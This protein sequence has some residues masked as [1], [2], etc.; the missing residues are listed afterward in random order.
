M[1]RVEPEPSWPSTWQYSYKYDLLELYGDDAS[2]GYTYAYRNRLGIASELIASVAAPPASV[3]DV[4]GGQGN[5]SLRL[6]E[7][8][9][10]VT[11]NDL[12]GDLAGYVALKHEHGQIDYRP[13]NL[14]DLDP[15]QPF[16]IVLLSEV[17][18]HVAH[19]D[20]L[21]AKAARLVAPGGSVVLTTPNGEY[22][23]NPLPKFSDC[24]DPSM[25]ESAQFKPDADGHIFLLYAGEVRSLAA[26][27]GLRVQTLQLFTNPVTTGH[28]RTA[29]LL[30]RLP[31]KAVWA[32]ERATRRLPNPISRKV[33]VQLAAVLT[34]PH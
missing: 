31:E 1:R 6:A 12:R 25:F 26:A 22:F 14:F 9:Y 15:A 19:P 32:L 11:W 3:L 21:L 4:A 34:R 33:N 13:G 20:Q 24:N 30:R 29:A 8:G 28:L 23:R 18:E 27:A 7:L 2:P 5:M 17:I 16:D 10:R